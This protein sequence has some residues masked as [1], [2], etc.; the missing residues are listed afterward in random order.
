MTLERSSS[1]RCPTAR[2][3]KTEGSPQ[4]SEKQ[5]IGLGLTGRILVLT[6]EK[7]T[8]DMSRNIVFKLSLERSSSGKCPTAR[9]RKTVGSPQAS[10]NN[11]M[12][13]SAYA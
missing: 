1:G 3:R 4:A 10:E 6:L 2:R 12:H 8:C 7:G 9:R 13:F 11:N 5:E